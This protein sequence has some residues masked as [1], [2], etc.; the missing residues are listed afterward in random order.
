MKRPQ[1]TT[2]CV[3]LMGPIYLLLFAG[4]AVAF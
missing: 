4:P 3:V 2:A 1:P